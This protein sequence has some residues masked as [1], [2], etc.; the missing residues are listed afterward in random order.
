MQTNM[1]KVAAVQASPAFL[2]LKQSIE[3]TIEL[4]DQAGKEGVQLLAFPETWI[5]GYPWYIWLSHPAN[6]IHYSAQY[7][8]NAI[9]ANS[10]HE[11]TISEA[12]KRNNLQVVLG[13]AEKDGG[14]LYMSQWHFAADGTV[15]SRRR[16]L[17][18][19]H[20][21]RSIFGEGDGSD[22]IVNDTALGKIGALCC[23]EHLQPLTKYAMYSQH[24]QIHIA[25]WPAYC[26]YTQRTY[27]LSPALSIA[28][29]Q[30][31]A[32]E[33]QCFVISACSVVSKEIHDLLCDTPEKQ[34]LMNVGG[35]FSQIF[36]P[37]G[38][39]MADYLPEEQEGLVCAEIDLNKIA[40]CKAAADPV[41]H[42]ARPDVFRL[43]FNNKPAPVVM[44][45]DEFNDT[46]P[47]IYTNPEEDNSNEQQ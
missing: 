27:A 11:K 47:E 13:V 31:Y 46:Q 44:S 21:E 34:A 10:V 35:G 20:V 42:Y 38:S 28:A 7:M 43:L 30:I 29:N 15:I 22:I 4:I 5:P 6:S 19:T 26:V 17:K 33:G 3:K 16:K 37:D 8:G 24:E 9:E 40:F 1:I 12:V 41:G 36:G 39:P 45:F 18:P 23:W 14:T 25:A 2:N 32:A